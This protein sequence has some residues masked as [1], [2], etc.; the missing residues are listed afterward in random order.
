MSVLK[1]FANKN[2]LLKRIYGSGGTLLTCKYH[3]NRSIKPPY[4]LP[5]KYFSNINTHKQWLN[6]VQS[7]DFDDIDSVVEYCRQKIDA[8]LQNSFEEVK[9]K[10]EI[11]ASQDS[12]V[13]QYLLGFILSIGSTVVE[14]IKDASSAD[15][16][17]KQIKRIQQSIIE[18]RK[19]KKRVLK[20]SPDNSK[21]ILD[22]A[23][24]TMSKEEQA[25]MWLTK[26]S[27]KNHGPSMTLLANILMSKNDKI[28]VF[29]AISWYKKA[30]QLDYTSSNAEALFSLGTLYYQGI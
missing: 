21:T 16:V 18:E 26:A 3:C 12:Q 15:E 17:V 30:A 14:S 29:E 19:L 7:K 1:L 22:T 11:A 2:C 24:I 4:F 9:F 10:L 13:A 27:K 20:G 23:N 8:D 5:V 28:S 6:E 25:I